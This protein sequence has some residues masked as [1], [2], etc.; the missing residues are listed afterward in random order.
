MELPSKPKSTKTLTIMAS[1]TKQTL[2]ELLPT[3]IRRI[4]GRWQYF[5]GKYWFNCKYDDP[6]LDLNA[7]HEVEKVFREQYTQASYIK[8][9]MEVCYKAWPKN[10]GPEH[11]TAEER[12]AAII[13]AYIIPNIQP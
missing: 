2:A 10:H 13:E 4:N 3:V 8:R 1:D 12:T 6:T 9:L 5:D 11:A 7:L